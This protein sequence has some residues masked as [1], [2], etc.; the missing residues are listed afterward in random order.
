M[1]QRN[2]REV[3]ARLARRS[4][5]HV[6]L[7]VRRLVEAHGE[8]AAGR[9]PTARREAHD[10]GR[11]DAAAEEV[12]DGRV[13]AQADAHGV[14]QPGLELA[15]RRVFASWLARRACRIVHVPIA[16]YPR[17]AVLEHQQMAGRHLPDAGEERSS[18]V[19][20]EEE[21]L[22]ERVFVP[23][24][25]QAGGEE[26][27]GFGREEQAGGAGAVEERLDAEAIAARHEPRAHIVP[28]DERKLAAQIV[29]GVETALFVEMDHD[30]AV[31]AAVK[32]MAARGEIVHDPL[33]AIEFAID[34]RRDLAGLVE[35]RLG[36]A[37]WIDD[38]QARVCQ[39]RVAA[40]AAPRSLAVRPAM[41][42]RSECPLGER[43]R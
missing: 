7:V 9:V 11:V 20:N 26:R 17:R 4:A 6:A 30:L 8:R 18:R 32:A 31:A 38:A 41:P 10:G 37:R 35:Q 43:V 27:L 28:D 36:A 23:V 5:R 12:R 39:Q 29:D 14:L 33:V 3:R 21:M 13:G 40:W 34:D 16:H 22:I 42:E 2:R 1:A 25:G 19:V 15:E 24:G